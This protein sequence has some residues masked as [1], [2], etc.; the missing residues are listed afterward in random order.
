MSDSSSFRRIKRIRKSSMGR[1]T[2]R[3]MQGS[4]TICGIFRSIRGLALPSFFMSSA[5]IAWIHIIKR[6]LSGEQMVI[7]IRSD[8]WKSSRVLPFNCVEWCQRTYCHH[9]SSSSSI[10]H[11]TPLRQLRLRPNKSADAVI[12]FEPNHVLFCLLCQWNLIL[13]LKNYN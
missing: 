6:V 7:S 12:W 5:V 11:P 1:Q 13:I 9:H 3:L 10:L 2:R 8:G 4:F